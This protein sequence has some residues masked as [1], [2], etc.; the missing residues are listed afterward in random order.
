MFQWKASFES[1]LIGLDCV[2]FLVL[3]LIDLNSIRSR[4]FSFNLFEAVRKNAILFHCVTKLKSSRLTIVLANRYAIY[5]FSYMH[6]Q[7]LSDVSC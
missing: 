3:G 6:F 2:V 5:F 4:I 1:S 7:S